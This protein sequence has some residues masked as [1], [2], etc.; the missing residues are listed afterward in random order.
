[1]F[2]VAL[3]IASLLSLLV[4][5]HLVNTWP[6]LGFIGLSVVIVLAYWVPVWPQLVSVAS[7]SIKYPDILIMTL[8][9][10]SVMKTKIRRHKTWTRILFG[11]LVLLFGVSVGRGVASSSIA[12]TVNEARPT[13]YALGVL[14][15][16]YT[17]VRVTRRA[18]V[19]IASWMLATATLIVLVAMINIGQNGLGSATSGLTSP[20]GEVIV[21]G[22]PI[23]SGQAFFLIA[24]F[25]VAISLW[26]KFRKWRHLALSFVFLAF[27]LVA[28]HRSVWVVAIVVLLLTWI[29]SRS[30]EKVRS[31]VYIP[32]VS[33]LIF[34]AANTWAPADRLFH[35]LS[36]SSTDDRTY[37]A[38]VMDWTALIGQ[39]I[40]A[41]PLTVATGLPFGSGWERVVEGNLQVS[42]VPHNMY[43]FAYLRIGLV[44][45]AILVGAAFLLIEL[46]LKSRSSFLLSSILAA[47][48]LYGW[49]YV[50]QWYLIP[51]LGFIVPLSRGPSIAKSSGIDDLAR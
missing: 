18:E 36:T 32:L 19:L 17:L 2:T 4:A 8:V 14:F 13:I 21:A 29:S 22:R 48:L 28:Q 45:L 6:S 49:T 7:L 46:A 41:G 11:S 10:A 50:P 51:I 9:A 31:M 5:A 39:S 35:Y 3:L 33:M 38:R 43:V 1:M 25:I 12:I 27:C 15:W 16:T 30:A 34:T 26:R 24:S 40:E 47:I 42:Y 37:L 23:N 20:S 44:G